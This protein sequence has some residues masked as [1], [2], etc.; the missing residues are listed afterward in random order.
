VPL[1]FDFL[2]PGARSLA[3]GSAF[4]GLADDATAALTN[5][6]GLTTLLRPEVSIEGRGR[7]TETRFLERGRLSGSPTG[8][9]IDTVAGPQYG[10][11]TSSAFRP[12]FAS[13]V[14]PHENRLAVA[15][16]YRELTTVSDRF[17]TQ[18]VFQMNPTL[19]TTRETALR[20]TREL[21]VKD[22][23]VAFAW[24][25]AST[26]SA[27]LGASIDTL[28]MEARFTRFVTFPIFDPA[29]YQP[30]RA[31]TE[32]VQTADDTGFGASAGVLWT[33]RRAFQLGAMF[34]RGPSFTFDQTLTNLPDESFQ[35][36]GRFKVP[37]TLAV[38]GA[39]RPAE[40][41]T[42]AFEY[43]FVQYGDLKHDY[44]DVQAEATGKKDQ[45]TIDDGSEVHLGVEYV[46]SRVHLTP[47][48][49]AGYW[50][51]PAHAVEFTPVDLEQTTEQR[52]AA[53][54]PGE[55]GLSHF[56]FGAGLP[57]SPRFELNAAAD[58]SSRRNFYSVF[59]VFRF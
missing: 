10:I 44:V 40:D 55:D 29:T 58:L 14:Y 38:G 21:S 20:A 37:D 56:T 43:T 31:I 27:G 46:L 9:G 30:D 47:A 6:A 36:S 35:S 1:E 24:R 12:A 2:N 45:F 57:V 7:Y 48:L 17:E 16:Y 49:R 39:V 52:Y 3:L 15:V 33:P 41:L 28:S 53:Y 13:F 22:Y 51:D 18:G 23:G 19:G 42:V 54:L 59:A 32:A 11:S 26:F 5:P 25:P 8:Q 4:V 50:Y 34:R